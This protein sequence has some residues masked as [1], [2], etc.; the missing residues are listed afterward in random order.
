MDLSALE[1]NYLDA[2]QDILYSMLTFHEDV[3]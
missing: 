1:I 2:L 3:K